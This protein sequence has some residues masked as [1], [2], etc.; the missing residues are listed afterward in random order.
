[1]LEPIAGLE[2]AVMPQKRKSTTSTS[3]P[4]CTQVAAAKA[5]AKA[6]SKAKSKPQAKQRGS[7]LHHAGRGH[8]GPHPWH[9]KT[10]DLCA[11]G[12]VLPDLASVMLPFLYALD[13]CDHPIWTTSLQD[14]ASSID[15]SYKYKRPRKPMWFDVVGNDDLNTHLSGF[16]REIAEEAGYDCGQEPQGTDKLDVS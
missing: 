10:M 14:A 16:Q 4:D 6:K 2:H 13:P 9:N 15:S 8:R 12:M 5:E 7:G 11:N 1:M 3:G